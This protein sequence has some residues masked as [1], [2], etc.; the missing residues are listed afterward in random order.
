MDTPAQSLLFLQSP[1][2]F[3]CLRIDGL[4]DRS[5]VSNALNDD[6][7]VNFRLTKKHVQML[8]FKIVFIITSEY[9]T[10]KIGSNLTVWDKQSLIIFKAKMDMKI[11]FC[12]KFSIFPVIVTVQKYFTRLHRQFI[13][14]HIKY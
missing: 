4:S 12:G 13:N 1:I 14:N 7:I 10:P 9:F 3:I 5:I 2:H 11:I 6:F 8:T